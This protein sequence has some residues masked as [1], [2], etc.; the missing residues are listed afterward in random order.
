MP[1]SGIAGPCGSF[2]F[3]SLRNLHTDFHS[4]CT[5]Q[6]LVT[7]ACNPRDSKGR[8]Q[9]DGGSRAAQANSL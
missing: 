8:D 1:K 4:G 2:I 9:E 5:S 6:A 3:S 7:H